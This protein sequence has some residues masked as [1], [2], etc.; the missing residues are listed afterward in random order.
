MKLHGQPH[1]L[2]YSLNF[3]KDTEDRMPIDCYPTYVYFPKPVNILETRDLNR[4]LNH[5]HPGPSPVTESIRPMS[6]SA[7]RHAP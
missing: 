4:R 3:V 6:D 1:H 2:L 7:V 5:W